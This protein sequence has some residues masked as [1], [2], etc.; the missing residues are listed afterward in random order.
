M[1]EPRT[2]GTIERVHLRQVW[3]H[4]ELDF[5]PWLQE[6]IDALGDVLDI[7]LASA[8][9]EQAA[10]P[11]SV[12]LL[13]E[14]DS[15]NPVVIENQLEKSDHD[16]LGK[17]L[18][19]LVSFDAR[20][21]VWIVADPRPEHVNVVNWLNESSANDFYLVKVEA[22]RIDHSNP[23][24]LFTLIVGPSPEARQVGK[25]KKELAERHHIRRDFWE[26][27]LER[28]KQRTRLHL[29]ITA[30]TDNWIS[31]GAGKAG[32][33]YNYVILQHSGRVEL[34]IDTGAT[35]ENKAI[36]DRLLAKRERIEEAFGQEL[37]WDHVEGRRSCY[38][39]Y[40]LEAGGYRDE[41]EWA[42]IQDAMIEAMIRLEEALRPHIAQL[43]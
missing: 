5:T 23:A 28:A 9:R 2:I 41:E 26:S 18:T 8:E 6:H 35:E 1:T 20:A 27:L 34:S 29:N 25:T 36:Y 38:I 13:A 33:V 16:H 24:P 12:D 14:D 15:G 32:L 39:R 37:D 43:N 40:H 11:F 22:I 3:P 10:G 31:T 30:S 42:A 4:E 19:Y 21:A 7:P 17:L